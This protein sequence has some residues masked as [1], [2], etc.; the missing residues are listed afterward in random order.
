MIITDN[1]LVVDKPEYRI[2]TYIIRMIVLARALQ[3]SKSTNSYE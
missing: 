2:I 1:T 3:K